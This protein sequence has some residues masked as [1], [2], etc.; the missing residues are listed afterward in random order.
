M[1]ELSNPK[2]FALAGNAT[3]TLESENTG[4]HFTYKIKQADDN[5]NVYFVKLLCNKDN[6]TDYTYVGCY[7]KDTGYFHPCKKWRDKDSL[8]WP[9]SMR[10]IRYFFNKIDKIPTKLHVYHEGRCGKCGRKLTTPDSIKRGFGP[11]CLKFGFMDKNFNWQN[12]LQN[13]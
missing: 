2:E 1:N 12:E 11:E 7:Y 9:P 6:E 5:A 13:G 10:A 3:I 4:K 8:S